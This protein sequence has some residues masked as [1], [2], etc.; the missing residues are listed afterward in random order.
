MIFRRKRPKRH[1]VKI[2]QIDA[3]VFDFDGVFTD[4]KVTIS[5]TGK[6]SVT[7]DRSDGM[8]IAMLRQLAIP[9]LILSTEANPVVTKRG[10]KLKVEVIQ[11]C[12]D[13]L[14]ALT[15]WVTEHNIDSARLAYVG[16]DINDLTCL[17]YAGISVAPF[18]ANESVKKVVDI[19]LTKH[20]GH[21]AIR[22]F[23]DLII[24][25]RKAIATRKGQLE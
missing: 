19:V 18:D 4:N 12:P 22:E 13:K 14:E 8:G 2:A 23:A 11:D 10:E 3:I 16:N 20:G 7:C 1:G 21:G 17:E 25:S 15:K 24:Q 9:I 5:E 6:E